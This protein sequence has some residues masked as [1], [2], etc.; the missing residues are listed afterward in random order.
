MGA[1]QI[2]DAVGLERG[3]DVQLP[4]PDPALGGDGVVGRIVVDPIDADLG[5]VK[6]QR[7]LHHLDVVAQLPRHRPER[8]VRDI[9]ARGGPGV[10]PAFDHVPGHRIHAGVLGDLR[11]IGRG[12]FEGEL[13]R[14]RIERPHAEL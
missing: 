14:V 8:T 11:Q 6:E 1:P 4:P 3:V 2:A 7:V 10:S 5:R 13:E 9:P 12:M